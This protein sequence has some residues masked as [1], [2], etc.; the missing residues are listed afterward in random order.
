MGDQPEPQ[1]A[2][3]KG[4]QPPSL[5]MSNPDEHDWRL[6][7]SPLIKLLRGSS[8]AEDRGTEAM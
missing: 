7:K 3:P 5:Q 1:Q 4:Q 2:P 6:N 8:V